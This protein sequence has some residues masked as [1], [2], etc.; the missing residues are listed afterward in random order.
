MF[1]RTSEPLPLSEASLLSLR[2]ALNAP[3]LNV[4]FLPVG[5]ARA[6]IVAF[7]E[8]WG[9]IGLA[10]GIRSTQGGQV[11]VFRNRLPLEPDVAIDRAMEPVIA[12]A[13]RMGFL[14]DED[15]VAPGSSPGGDRARA[16]ALWG[17]LMGDVEMPPPPRAAPSEPAAREPI[18]DRADGPAPAKTTAGAT[19]PSSPS[20]EPPNDG[21]TLMLE[22][23]AEIDLLEI[24]LGPEDELPPKA[25]L[26][27]QALEPADAMTATVGPQQ[28]VALSSVAPEPPAAEGD[29][30]EDLPAV[31][32]RV[33]E[34][35]LSK[36][37]QVEAGTEN[38]DATGRLG[39]IPIVK[40]RR[41][42]EG[43]VRVPY[44]ARL[45]SSF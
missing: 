16:L 20:I 4:G 14:F 21:V 28:E 23:V 15:M 17:R 6:A 18:L 19:A 39:R 8:E 12:E 35:R 41:G 42:R 30:A 43:R 2:P 22:E 7:G 9:G 31:P 3:V 24:S 27:E 13:E 34:A 1:K 11:A 10:L 32:R 38:T 36:F 37:R 29:R 40:V 26:P 45:L 5:P 25:P 44:L 33:P